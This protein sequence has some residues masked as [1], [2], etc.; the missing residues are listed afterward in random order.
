MD[1][2]RIVF[3]VLRENSLYVK[4]KKKVF[5]CPTF[6]GHWIGAGKIWMVRRYRLSGTG[7]SL[8]R[9]QRSFLGLVNYYRRFI[10]GYSRPLTDLLKKEK[11]WHWTDR[12]QEAFEDLKQAV[13]ALT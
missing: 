7:N 3:K 4:K 10:Q 9:S 1:H 6:L 8:L 12:C 13:I 5:L 2:L 11:A